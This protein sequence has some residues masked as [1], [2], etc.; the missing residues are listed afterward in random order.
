VL[1]VKMGIMGATAGMV[2][3]AVI[4]GLVELIFRMK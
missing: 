3:G 4:A 1:T 2:G